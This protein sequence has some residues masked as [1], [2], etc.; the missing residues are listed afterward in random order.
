MRLL[1][2]ALCGVAFWAGRVSSKPRPGVGTRA[3]PAR[4][5]PSPTPT[6]QSPGS[7]RVT[8][9]FVMPRW[10]LKL[11]T[12]GS[13]LLQPVL[14]TTA[15]TN[16]N[17]GGDSLAGIIAAFTK[18][19]HDLD[20]TGDALHQ[21]GVRTGFGDDYR[22]LLRELGEARMK[23]G[24]LFAE[25]IINNPELTAAADAVSQASDKLARDTE[26]TKL[27]TATAQDFQAV[28][29]GVNTFAGIANTL[30]TQV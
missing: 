27:P 22:I 3:N 29:D 19:G 15:F 10:N 23:V 11:N 5:P 14:L 25:D 30:G 12:T 16:A 26:K 18:A 20:E 6:G 21:F 9:T 28:F 1:T 2:F 13:G 17:I 4:T 24:S 7:D 8:K